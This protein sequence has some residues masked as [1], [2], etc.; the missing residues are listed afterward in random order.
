MVP[1]DS[2]VRLRCQPASWVHGRAA[3]WNRSE[4]GTGRSRAAKDQESMNL[5]RMQPDCAP[6]AFQREGL[7]L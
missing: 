6:R 1:M 5:R 7:R 2:L 4:A 3:A